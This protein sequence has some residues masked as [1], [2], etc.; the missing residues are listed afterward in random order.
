[1]SS[2]STPRKESKCDS[3]FVNYKTPCAAPSDTAFILLQ[4]DTGINYVVT[5]TWLDVKNSLHCRVQDCESLVVSTLANYKNSFAVVRH[6]STVA[7]RSLHQCLPYAAKCM[8]LL[9]MYVPTTTTT[10]AAYKS[11]WKL[12]CL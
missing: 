8:L 11:V 4:V 1:M 10:A 2:T 6:N 9:R 5:V 7:V 12:K 3:D